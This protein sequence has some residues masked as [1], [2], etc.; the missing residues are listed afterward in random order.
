[1]STFVTIKEFLENGGILKKGID[2]FLEKKG[3]FLFAGIL[4]E[5]NVRVFKNLT[6]P[7][8]PEIHYVNIKVI[9]IYD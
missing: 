2:I 7:I 6:F 4:D 1:M 3:H 5:N 9:P 8:E